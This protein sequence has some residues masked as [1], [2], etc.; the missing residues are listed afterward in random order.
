MMRNIGGLTVFCEIVS[1]PRMKS[2]PPAPAHNTSTSSED[3]SPDQHGPLTRRR[4][5]QASSGAGLALASLPVARFA[6]A[7][8]SDQ[9][10]V[11]LVGC[12]GRGTGAANQNLN[13]SKGIK[14]V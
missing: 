14:V 3:S 2:S 9:L 1:S 7:A 13:T 8:G 10:K 11:A 12:G 6:H 4:F 5:L